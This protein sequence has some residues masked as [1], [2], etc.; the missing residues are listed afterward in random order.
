MIA[1]LRRICPDA[2]IVVICTQPES[3]SRTFGVQTIKLTRPPIASRWIDR[4]NRMLGRAPYKMFGPVRAFLK[5]RGFY[6][7]VLPGTGAF[8]DFGDTPFGMPYVFL[9][10]LLMA[11]LRGCV[12]AFASI[13]AGPA[14]HPL[15]RIFF[16]WAARCG[17]YRS[18]RDGISRE[19]V[20]SL[21]VS[22]AD[23]PIFP[24]L[25]FG[26]PMPPAATRGVPNSTVVGLGVMNY[27]GSTGE[28]RQIYETYVSKLTEFVART[29]RRGFGVRLI[30]GQDNDELAV[31]DMIGRL[32][33]KLS[34]PELA[35]VIYERSA[36][37]HDVMAQMQ[38]TD[39]V[40]A[41]RFH[42]VVCAMRVGLPVISLGYLEKHNALAADAG[43]SDFCTSVE[44]FSLE[45]LE[46]RLETL[47]AER[48][49]REQQMR[50]TVSRYRHQLL[51]QEALL[52]TQ[53]FGQAARS[54]S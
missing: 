36:S 1:A 8:D 50:E 20:G 13:G 14:Y 4:A 39:L 31:A 24:D 10:W 11:R 3:V 53:V 6:A 16:A 29:V 7:V 17:S 26:L 48:E 32:R 19:F 40:V 49:L 51:R 47:L 25:A 15:S 54:L 52:R 35:Q 46:S 9:K 5:L 42:N 41:T 33:G 43:L 38:A 12:V 34:A 45:W 22:S 18:F 23:D 37:L 44:T 28:N 30:L 2:E 21:G 27:F